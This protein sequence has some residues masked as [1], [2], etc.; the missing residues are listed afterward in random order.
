MIAEVADAMEGY[1]L[2]VKGVEG[3][4]QNTVEAILVANQVASSVNRA[5]RTRFVSQSGQNLCCKYTGP[6]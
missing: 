1:A 5:G 4:L 3:H 6:T 2:A